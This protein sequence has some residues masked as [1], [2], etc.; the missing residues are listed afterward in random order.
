MGLGTQFANHMEHTLT[1][2]LITS[3]D[4]CDINLGHG[5]LLSMNDLLFFIE[6]KT[7]KDQNQY[8]RL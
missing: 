8:F 3:F 2:G 5:W 4:C 1:L 6:N 7:T